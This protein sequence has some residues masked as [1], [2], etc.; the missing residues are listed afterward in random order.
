MFDIGWTELLL[1]GIVALIVVGPKDLPGMFRTL[2]RFSAR[3]RSMAREFQRA[4][5]QAADESGV[6]DIATDLRTATSARRLGLD[7]LQDSARRFQKSFKDETSVGASAKVNEEP[8]G[9]K[10][11][12]SSD[13]GGV[14]KDQTKPS[15]LTE[16][17]AQPADT[18][19]SGSGS[20]NAVAADAGPAPAETVQQ[21]ALAAEPVE[22]SKD[23]RK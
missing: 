2:G 5:E 6:K 16:K 18:G 15:D 3:M 13:K 4:M 17:A 22:G 14:D 11:V 8:A 1:I 23:A 10:P 19:N 20:E 7:T 12:G 9:K 21:Q